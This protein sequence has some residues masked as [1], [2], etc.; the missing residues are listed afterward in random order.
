[1]LLLGPGSPTRVF[2]SIRPSLFR[3]GCASS[4]SRTA[5]GAGSSGLSQFPAVPQSP[6]AAAAD[7][8]AWLS[9]QLVST[10][11]TLP[12]VFRFPEAWVLF[13]RA[14]CAAPAPALR[15]R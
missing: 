2:S 5:A 6:N 11:G 12:F 14:A 3:S 4:S 15:R 13:L 10:L 7:E 1:L 8:H 9:R